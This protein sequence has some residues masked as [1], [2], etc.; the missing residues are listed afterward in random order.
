MAYL[1][2]IQTQESIQ[3]I[4]YITGGKDVVITVDEVRVPE[5]D[6][7]LVAEEIVKI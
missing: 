3:D 7:Q 1:L 5:L 2:K 6:A 4:E